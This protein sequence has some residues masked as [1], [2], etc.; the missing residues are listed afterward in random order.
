MFEKPLS[1]GWRRSPLDHPELKA[2]LQTLDIIGLAFLVSTGLYAVLVG[3]GVIPQQESPATGF[4]I[5]WAFAALAAM[6]IPVILLLGAFLLSQAS[7][8]S[9]A[10]AAFEKGRAAMIVSLAMAEAVAIF[11]LVAFLLGASSGAAF[12]FIATG[13]FLILLCLALFRPRIL[14]LVLDKLQKEQKR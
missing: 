4:P 10:V 5:E 2:R 13:A 12:G 11:G 8:E 14:N 3:S 6:E 9:S 7:A 1:R